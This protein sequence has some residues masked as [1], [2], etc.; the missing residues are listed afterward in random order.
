MTIFVLVLFLWNVCFKL[1]IPIGPEVLGPVFTVEHIAR[2]AFFLVPYNVGLLI[3]IWFLFNFRPRHEYAYLR[4]LLY[5]MT[6]ASI[7][8]ECVLLFVPWKK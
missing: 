2:S 6:A 5:G 7:L 8:G 3:V 4:A 1:L